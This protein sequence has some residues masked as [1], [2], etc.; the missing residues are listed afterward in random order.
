[1]VDFRVA[2][3][4]LRSNM[5]RLRNLLTEYSDEEKQQLGIPKNAISRGGKWYVGDTYVGKVVQGKFVPVKQ[6]SATG[7]GKKLSR[8]IPKKSSKTASPSILKKVLSPT[9]VTLAQ[10]LV[11]QFP[12]SASSSDIATVVTRTFGRTTPIKT[13]EKSFLEKLKN[14]A[15]FYGKNVEL[16]GFYDL[17]TDTIVL[18]D[19]TPVNTNFKKNS[20]EDGEKLHIQIHESIHAASPRLQGVKELGNPVD[21]MIE[22]GL[23]EALTKEITINMARTQGA[24]AFHR[25]KTPYQPYEDAIK[26]VAQTNDTD[27]DELFKLKTSNELRTTVLNMCKT[28]IT[29]QLLIAFSEKQTQ[30]IID[31]FKFATKEYEQHGADWGVVLFSKN[32]LNA[33]QSI[34]PTGKNQ[35]RIL[36]ALGMDENDIKEILQA[37]EP[38]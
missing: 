37:G 26:Y 4:V 2:A 7:Q 13:R 34:T 14:K 10:K 6:K 32:I 17:E 11:E 36:T 27:L 15:E 28:Q 31:K 5:I 8:R 35:R 19:N 16:M 25:I 21:R 12:E 33:I 38:I 22:E 24:R 1:M 30:L 9:T 20:Y 3:E 29:K 18:E 23:T